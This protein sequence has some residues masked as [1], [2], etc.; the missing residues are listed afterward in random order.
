MLIMNKSRCYYVLTICKKK[1][2]FRKILLQF[3]SFFNMI[4]SDQS[5]SLY[6]Y[7]NFFTSNYYYC[8]Q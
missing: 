2:C 8:I 3:S 1:Y 7:Y 5:A 6:D 4:C